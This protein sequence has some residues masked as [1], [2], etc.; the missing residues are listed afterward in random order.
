MSR[1]SLDIPRLTVHLATIVYPFIVLLCYYCEVRWVVGFVIAF[2]LSSRIYLYLEKK[3]A[4]FYQIGA[5]SASALITLVVT[6]CS[7][8]FPLLL[9]AI[10]NFSLLGVFG[11]SLFSTHNVIEHFARSIKGELP[12][13]GVIHCR[14]TCISWCAFFFLNGCIAL[15]SVHRDIRWWSLYNGCIGY[16][17]MGCMFLG[18]YW[19]RLRTMKR[20]ASRQTLGGVFIGTIL[21]GILLFGTFHSLRAQESLYEESLPLSNLQNILHAP[22]PFKADF[23]ERKVVKVLSAPL[24]SKGAVRCIPGKGI[25]WNATHPFSRTYAITRFGIHSY[26]GSTITHSTADRAGISDAMLSL[27][28]G[29]ISQAEQRFNITASGKAERWRVSLTPKDSL[30]S[31]LIKSISVQGGEFPQQI[32]VTH[33][34]GDRVVTSFTPPTP[35]SDVEIS[36]TRE[37]LDASPQ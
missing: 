32:E 9:P 7:Q 17:G 16:C 23:I 1:L 36:S 27:M 29:E 33:E 22:P 14:Y 24:E 21:S 19:F 28:S 5:V 18:E 37:L 30:V 12:P 34:N 26:K 20:V 3:V 8:S 25:V 35:L 6:Q 2:L 10:I 13:E 4:R 15:D 11:L 31:Q